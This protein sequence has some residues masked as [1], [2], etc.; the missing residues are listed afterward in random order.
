[1]TRALLRSTWSRITDGLLHSTDTIIKRLL[2]VKRGKKAEE[3]VKAGEE[4]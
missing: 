2:T 3:R 1:M 4:I